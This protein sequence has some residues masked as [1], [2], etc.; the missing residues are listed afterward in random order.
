M[1]TYAERAKEI[2]KK[3]EKFQGDPI[4]EHSMNLE[5][6]QLAKEQ[7]EYKTQMAYGGKKK[8]GYGGKKKMELGGPFD[9]IFGFKAAGLIGGEG[10]P[11]PFRPIDQIEPV[12]AITPEGSGGYAERAAL[13]GDNT[14]TEGPS[15]VSKVSGLTDESKSTVP[16][17]EDMVP[18]DTKGLPAV[19]VDP[20]LSTNKSAAIEAIANKEGAEDEAEKVGWR[21]MA[22]VAGNMLDLV[23]AIKDGPQQVNYETMEAPTISGEAAKRDTKQEMDT[24]Y[25][26]MRK[27]SDETSQSSGQRLGRTAA[28]ESARGIGISR[29]LNRIQEDIDNRNLQMKFQTDQINTGIINQQIADQMAADMAHDFRISQNVNTIGGAFAAQ[30]AEQNQADQDFI[31]NQRLLAAIRSGILRDFLIDNNL[32]I[33]PKNLENGK[34]E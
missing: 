25:N 27:A 15:P 7:E 30:G 20:K 4:S 14:S 18:A 10:T 32:E 5:L 26:N 19:D 28:L 13:M 17:S 1:A 31:N 3:Y 9:D 34:D 29:A 11:I 6:A 33:T 2:M 21:G 16:K 8:M 23:N 22:G 12:V 24:A